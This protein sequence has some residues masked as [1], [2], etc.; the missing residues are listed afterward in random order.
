[1]P[2]DLF[3]AQHEVLSYDQTFTLWATGW[4]NYQ[5]PISLNWKSVKFEKE[6]RMAI[7]ENQGIYA[8]FVEPRVADFR[9]H[10]YL[11]YIGETG[12]DSNNNLRERFSQYFSYKRN[13]KRP[14]IHWLLNNWEG[15]LYFYYVEIP[16]N[17]MNL[18]ELETMLLDTFLPPY[19]LKD[20][21]AEIGPRTR[22]GR[23]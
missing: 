18:N 15:Y 17:T 2:S 7:P 1:M 13:Y 16:H 6:N 14:H 11:M 4:K 21:S 19:N 8:F 22:R 10:A 5:V 12:Q 23:L 20:F 3:N 9:N